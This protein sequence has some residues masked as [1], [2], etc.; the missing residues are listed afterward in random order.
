MRSGSAPVV[1]TR[2]ELSFATHEDYDHAADNPLA[3]HRFSCRAGSGA[4]VGVLADTR[5]HGGTVVE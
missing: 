5:R 1:I 2:L 4:L 3:S